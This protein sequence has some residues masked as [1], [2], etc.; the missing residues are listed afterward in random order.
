M[1]EVQVAIESFRNGMVE[2][3][4]GEVTPKVDRG[5][6]SLLRFIDSKRQLRS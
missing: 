5:I 2:E 4:D 6:Q 1:L 3:N